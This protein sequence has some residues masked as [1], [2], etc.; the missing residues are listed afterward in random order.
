[1]SEKRGF[2][3]FKVSFPFKVEG[4]ELGYQFEGKVKDISMQ[5]VRI[6]LDKSLGVLVSE[7]KFLDIL[8]PDR[9]LRVKGEVAWEKEFNDRKEIGIHF[10]NIADDHKEDI[11]D[12]ILKY[13]RP[14]LTQQWWSM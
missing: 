12:Y 9:I 3:R 11:Y 14:E 1:M 7:S 13:H 8:L 2:L 10:S 4:K 5:G 6:T